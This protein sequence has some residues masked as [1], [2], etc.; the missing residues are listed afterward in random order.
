MLQAI[1]QDCNHRNI[2]IVVER[3]IPQLATSGLSALLCTKL[4]I[5]DMYMQLDDDLTAEMIIEIHSSL[6]EDTL[7]KALITGTDLLRLR[8][9]LVI[10]IR[11]PHSVFPN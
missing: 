2:N 10:P 1:A 4:Q 9:M 11:S 6:Y 8:R 7:R 3:A 5:P